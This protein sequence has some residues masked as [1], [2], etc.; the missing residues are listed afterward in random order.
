MGKKATGSGISATVTGTTITWTGAGR[1]VSFDVAAVEPQWANLRPMTQAAILNGFR[2]AGD[3]MTALER[4]PITKQS[5]TTADKIERVARRV[6][7][8]VAGEWTLARGATGPRTVPENLVIRAMIRALAGI[9]NAE[10]VER[11][12]GLQVK[13]GKAPDRATALQLWAKSKQVAAAILAIEAEIAAERVAGI[14]DADAEL[15]AIMALADGGEDDEDGDD[16]P[17]GDEALV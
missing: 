11:V 4:D 7:G 6:A 17:R 13:A 2:V 8:W 12:L 1:T 9:N 10:D 5:A 14:D 16:E 15:A 3:R